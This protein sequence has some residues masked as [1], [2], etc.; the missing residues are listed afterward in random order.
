MGRV[1]EEAQQT[2]L[3]SPGGYVFTSTYDLAGDLSSLIYPS[4]RKV[5]YQ[6]NNAMQPTQVRYDSFGGTS[7]GYNYLSSASY[8]PMGAPTSTTLGSGLV[9]STAYNSR[10][11]PSSQQLATG[12]LT[13]L[14]RSYGYG[15]SGYDNGNVANI[16]D[17]LQSNRT[18]AF[19]YDNLNRITQ[20]STTGTSGAGCFGETYNIDAYGN[21][22]GMGG[23]SGY[24]CVQDNLSITIGSNNGIS[25]SG[26]SY[27]ASGDLLGDGYNS[28]TFDAENRISTYNSGTT[29][30]Y[31]ALGER[32][33]KLIGSDSTEYMFFKGQS[34][35]ERKANGDWSD[36]VYAGSR[37][38]ARADD[39]EDRIH[40]TGN[41]GSAGLG[42]GFTFGTLSGVTGYVIQTG[43]KFFLRQ[44]QSGAARGGI[45]IRFTDSTYTNW[46]TTDQD[47][48]ALNDDATTSSW[49]Y[50]AVDLS[51]CCVGKTIDIVFLVNDVNS[52]SGLWDIYYNDVAIVSADGTVH[53]IYNRQTSIAL[54]SWGS[55]GVSGVAYEV[56]HCCDGSA[57]PDTTTMYYHGDQLGSARLMTG[58]DGYPV[59]SATYAPYGMELSAEATVNHYKFTGQERDAEST[60]DYFHARYFSSMDGRFLTPDPA[61]NLVADPADPQSWNQYA[62]VRNNPTNMIDPTGLDGIS[63]CGPVCWIISGI[64]DLFGLF[65]GGGHA[66]LPP[67][68]TLPKLSGPDPFSGSSI[69][70][71]NGMDIGDPTAGEVDGIPAG[72]QLPGLGSIG[73]L[74]GC[75]Y[76]AGNCGGIIYGLTAAQQAAAARQR[77]LDYL[78]W[79]LSRPWMLSWIFPVLG[80]PGAAGVGPAG[81]VVYNPQTHTVCA[82]IGIGA[83]VGDNVSIGPLTQVHTNPGYKTDGIF[84]GGSLSGG[85]NTPIGPGVQGTINSAG[86][87]GGWDVG[88]P[89]ASAS[90]TTGSCVSLN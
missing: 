36:Y 18:Q 51:S 9:E 60:N 79:L 14:N 4:G 48:Y 39:Y 68:K 46:I 12:A 24:S 5:T 22:Y 49:H 21:L 80:E 38:L 7:V 67:R 20:A 26:F 83:S 62:Y 41:N 2:P 31:D 76:G 75:T 56:N 6:Y 35:A 66:T 81:S 63:D 59:W 16:T 17:S 78:H 65:G 30:F 43:D 55:S 73:P 61:G 29:Y 53:P 58:Y 85:L 47:G 71:S 34:V 72:M 90:S 25:T 13:W 50:R 74:G 1:V 54:S 57:P 70:D 86:R 23:L 88:V 10:L 28:Y 87:A 32:G 64:F 19:V 40:V 15:S 33:E 84:R 44:Y 77:I 89:G 27:D 52:G 69:G 82:S 8:A 37:L 42:T 3:S 11:Q 45:A